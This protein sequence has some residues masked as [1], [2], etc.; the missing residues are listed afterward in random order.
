MGRL[1]A[2]LQTSALDVYT[3]TELMRNI[4]ETLIDGTRT[5]VFIAHR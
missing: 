2:A 1:T 5:S 4:N 3:E